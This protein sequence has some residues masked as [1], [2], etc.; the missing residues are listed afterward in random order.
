MCCVLLLNERC[1]FGLSVWC[2]RLNVIFAVPCKAENYDEIKMK[3]KINDTEVG[4][5]LLLLLFGV[6][7]P[8]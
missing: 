3:K 2:S 5:C 1:R 4:F 8:Y 7:C 6:G